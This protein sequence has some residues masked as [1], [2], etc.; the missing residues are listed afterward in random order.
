MNTFLTDADVAERVLAHVR[1][2]T[3]DRGDS[4]WRGP[5]ENYR[6][7][8]RLGRER[9]ALMKVPVAV[10]PSSALGEAGSFIARDVAGTPLIV[11]RG[12]DGAVRA[13]RNACRHRGARLADGS[14]CARAFVCPYHGWAY[15][16][17]G[18]LQS[19]PHED[20]FPGLDKSEHGLAEVSAIERH[21]LVFVIQAPDG[22]AETILDDLPRLLSQDQ[23]IITVN[24]TVIDANWKVHLESFIEGYHIKYAH[25]ETFYPFGYDN[26][27]LVELSGWHARVTYPFRRIEKLA[28]VAPADRKVE[29]ALTYVYHLFP[30]A[31]VTVLSHHTN[32]VVLDP[33]DTDRTVQITYQMSNRGGEDAVEAARRD[34]SFVADSGAREDR[35]LVTGIQRG[36][37]SGANDVFTFGHFEAAIAHFHRNLD[38]VIGDAS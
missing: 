33:I 14:G 7:P 16:L 29:G 38:T 26:L 30:N 31:L 11:V 25:P 24:E 32:L 3:T 10:C 15:R 19:I 13:F 36:L 1:D 6:S 21:G 12:Q 23:Q 28:G 37:G 20:G 2:G 8:Q 18:K 4:V 22:D 27:N 35:D 17:D 34:A 9:D 5:V